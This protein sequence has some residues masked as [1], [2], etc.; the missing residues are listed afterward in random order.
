[1]PLRRDELTVSELENGFWIERLARLSDHGQVRAF[2]ITPDGKAIVFDRLRDNS[3]IFLI[4]L[5]K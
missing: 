4:D 1:V 2:D 5:P 3:D